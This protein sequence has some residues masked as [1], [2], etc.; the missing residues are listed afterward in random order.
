MT[1]SLGLLLLLDLALSHPPAL[2]HDARIAL[3]SNL[4]FLSSSTHS[5]APSDLPATTTCTDHRLVQYRQQSNFS[6]SSIVAAFISSPHHCYILIPS[7]AR[8]LHLESVL[9]EN[10]Q[11]EPPN[12]PSCVCYLASKRFSIGSKSPLHWIRLSP[13]HS[14][15]IKV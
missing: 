15:Q 14:F 1:Q 5:S 12:D 13:I 7:C 2:S 4:S 3:V 11:R 10:W 6:A 8:Q 9:S